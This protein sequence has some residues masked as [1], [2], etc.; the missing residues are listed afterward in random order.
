MNTILCKTSV[1][2][3]LTLLL[4]VGCTSGEY[5]ELGQVQGQV[6]MD[7]QPLP[8]ALVRFAPSSGRPAMGVTDEQGNYQLIYV[9]DIRGAEP[10]DYNVEITTWFRPETI[11][12]AHKKRT[13][14]I[15]AK[16][17]KR[18]TLTAKV[19]QGQNQIDFALETK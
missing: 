9:R 8:K 4:S 11:E 13:E 14:T 16:Y 5:S 17:N 6:T 15:P 10:G 3:L 7:G 18:T 12:D 19:E 2:M 1:A